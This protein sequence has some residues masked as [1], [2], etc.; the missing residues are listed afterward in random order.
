M[1]ILKK[2]TIFS[3]LRKYYRE[4]QDIPAKSYSTGLK[5]LKSLENDSQLN[6]KHSQQ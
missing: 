2:F 3:K 5:S 1:K 6:E 4:N